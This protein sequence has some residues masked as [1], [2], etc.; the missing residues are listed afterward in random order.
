MKG[1]VAGLPLALLLASCSSV[2]LA[3]APASPAADQTPDTQALEALNR[4]V[5]PLLAQARA[6]YP[7]AKRRFLAGLPQGDRFYVS[8]TLKDPTGRRQQA[9][10][11]VATY[12]GNTVLGRI[13]SDVNRISGYAVGDPYTGEESAVIDWVII[14]PDG[15]EEGKFVGRFL[16]G[17]G[18]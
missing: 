9:Y 10:V 13:A 7:E 14:H 5:Q 16:E 2:P 4:A 3:G 8:V 1:A 11:Y 6:T 12:Q 17:K 15:S 18:L